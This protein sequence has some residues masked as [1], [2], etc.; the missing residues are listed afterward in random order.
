ME[1]HGYGT[2]LVGLERCRYD[3]GTGAVRRLRSGRYENCREAPVYLA[4]MMAG[5]GHLSGRGRV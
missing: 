3:L 2:D 5:A 4:L 1:V